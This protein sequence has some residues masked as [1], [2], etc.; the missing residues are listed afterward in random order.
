[1]PESTNSSETAANNAETREPTGNEVD[2]VAAL[3]RGEEPDQGDQETD[4][5][6]EAS[7]ETNKSKGKPKNLEGLAETLGVE[8]KDL[9]ALEIPFADGD[10]VE[11]KTLGEIKDSFADRSTFEVDKMAWEE[12]RT[13]REND[14]VK[15]TQ[16]LQDIVS[17]LPKS[18]LSS[19]LIEKVAQRRAD[20]VE[21]ETRLTRQ[22]IPDWTDEGRETTDRA[23]MQEHLAEYGFPANY[24]DS[25]VDHKTLRFI[26]E[27]M[28]RQQRIERALAQVKT[29]RKA[30][31]K[32]S[33][34]PSGKPAPA[35]KGK[36][37]SRV[38]SQ[39]SQVA[40]LLNS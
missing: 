8:V 12:S 35:S 31:H 17:L 39:V 38:R 27:S 30:G 37:S 10:D 14:L 2:Q 26:R 16:E 34:K 7:S 18:A 33:G 24:L 3:L 9:Y 1:M 20:L 22:V 36:T 40:E 5:T 25:I 32:P 23:A 29:V 28:L 19:Q 15:S 4:S 21:T 13:Q 6:S 11:Q